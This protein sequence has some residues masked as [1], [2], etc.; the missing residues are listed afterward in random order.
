[1]SVNLI[2][3]DEGWNSSDVYVRSIL[4]LSSTSMKLKKKTNTVKP[5]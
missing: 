2:K 4:I 5:A 1:M 3:E